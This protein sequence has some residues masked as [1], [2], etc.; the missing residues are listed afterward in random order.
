MQKVTKTTWVCAGGDEFDSPNEALQH[1]KESH[2]L[3]VDKL[4]TAI[5]LTDGHTIPMKA[6]NALNL[7]PDLINRISLLSLEID[8]AVKLIDE[9]MSF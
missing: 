4:A 5:Q 8:Q 9:E 1:L 2:E 6:R 7:N 3:A